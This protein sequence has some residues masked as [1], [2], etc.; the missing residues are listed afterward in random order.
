MEVTHQV[1]PEAIRDLGYKVGDLYADTI[2]K[3]NSLPKKDR[4]A[5]FRIMRTVL[6]PFMEGVEE[7]GQLG[8][9]L[10]VEVND[11]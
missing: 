3:A 11:E 1:D 10:I 7:L 8:E 2:Y 5:L 6:S 4:D 9:N